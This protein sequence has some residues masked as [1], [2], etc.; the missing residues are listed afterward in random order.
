[1]CPNTTEFIMNLSAAALCCPPLLPRMPCCPLGLSLAGL[2]HTLTFGFSRLRPVDGDTGQ[3]R[4]AVA[5]SQLPPQ[6]AGASQQTG[7]ALHRDPLTPLTGQIPDAAQTGRTVARPHAARHLWSCRHK[8]RYHQSS[9]ARDETVVRICSSLPKPR[10]PKLMCCHVNT[11]TSLQLTTQRW[12]KPDLPG[13]KILRT[14][15]R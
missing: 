11:K 9:S 4:L 2:T 15:V 13:M 1:M 5:A 3:P 12:N 6:F 7:L 14:P 10:D 8:Y